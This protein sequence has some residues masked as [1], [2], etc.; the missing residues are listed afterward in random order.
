[1]NE[2]IKHLEEAHYALEKKLGKMQKHPHVGESKVAEIKKQKLQLKDQIRDLQERA[3]RKEK[4]SN[5]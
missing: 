3:G 2:H 5:D 4:E 1:M